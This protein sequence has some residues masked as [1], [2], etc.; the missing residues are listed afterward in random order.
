MY[1]LLPQQSSKIVSSKMRKFFEALPQKVTRKRM[2]KIGRELRISKRTITNYAEK[3]VKENLL[4]KEGRG[5][6]KKIQ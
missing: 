6:Y 1:Q 2:D 5:E 4:E 3:L